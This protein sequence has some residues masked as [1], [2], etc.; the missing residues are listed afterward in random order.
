MILSFTKLELMAIVKISDQNS[1]LP[2]SV[3]TSFGI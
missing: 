2:Y 1:Q 3:S